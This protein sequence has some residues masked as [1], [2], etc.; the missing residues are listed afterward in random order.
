MHLDCAS[1]LTYGIEFH[2]CPFAVQYSENGCAN[3]HR[4]SEY[5][6]PVSLAMSEYPRVAD[7]GPRWWPGESPLVAN[8]SPHLLT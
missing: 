4:Q 1:L 3:Y 2:V 8:K 6:Q 5:Q 7:G